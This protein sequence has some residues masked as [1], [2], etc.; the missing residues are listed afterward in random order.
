MTQRSAGTIYA[1]TY[2]MFAVPW[3]NKKFRKQ[4]LQQLK[5]YVTNNNKKQLVHFLFCKKKSQNPEFGEHGS[6]S[7]KRG[8]V[9]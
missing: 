2:L 7:Q 1:V 9:G 4:S 5:Y 6:L 3:L 8:E